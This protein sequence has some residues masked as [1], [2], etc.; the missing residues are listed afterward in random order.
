MFVTLE[1]CW[2]CP[3]CGTAQS[4]DRPACE[5]GHA[6]DCPDRL[7]SA[8]ATAFVIDPP[9]PAIRRTSRRSQRRVRTSRV[10]A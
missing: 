3:V 2:Q 8:C 4:F 7:C 1:T 5:D 9:R 10:A 6:D